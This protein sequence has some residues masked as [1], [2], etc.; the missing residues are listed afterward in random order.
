MTRARF[1]GAAFPTALGDAKPQRHLF[2]GREAAAAE[3]LAK[4]HLQPV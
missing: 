3:I 2:I 4:A 1:L